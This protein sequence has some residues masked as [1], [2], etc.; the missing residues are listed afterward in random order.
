MHLASHADHTGEQERDHSGASEQQARCD[1]PL[2]HYI[3]IGMEGS[4]QKTAGSDDVCV[5]LSAFPRREEQRSSKRLEVC[6][7]PTLVIGG[8]TRG[9]CRLLCW[10]K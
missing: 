3:K 8:V 7:D 6:I 2:R 10:S 5:G 9:G 1:D 4:K